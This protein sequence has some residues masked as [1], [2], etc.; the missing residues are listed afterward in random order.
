MGTMDIVGNVKVRLN[1]SAMK[2][3]RFSML[4]SAIA[5]V[6][7][8]MSCTQKSQDYQSVIPESPVVVVKA[9]VNSL[10]AKSELL[11]DNQVTGFA[12]SAINEM[13]ENTRGIL[14]EILNDPANSGLDLDKPAFVVV[15]NIENMRGFAL[16]AVSDREKVKALVNAIDDS[17]VSLDEAADYSLIKLR[18]DNLGALDDS[19]L[20]VAFAQGAFDASEYMLAED[21]AEWSDELEDFLASPEELGYYMAYRDI[22]R[23]AEGMEA[24]AFSGIDVEKFKDLKLVCNVNFNPG[25]A[26]M[27][28]SFHGSDEVKRMYKDY[29]SDAET[30][31]QRFL[32]SATMALLQGGYKNLGTCM[33]ET[34][35]NDPQMADILA[36]LNRDLKQMGAKQ[37]FT[38]SLLNSLDGG[39]VL[40]VSEID[41][42]ADLPLPQM[43]F[44]AECKDDKLFGMI[45]E[46]LQGQSGLVSKTAENVYLVAGMYYVGYADSKLFVMPAGIFNECYADNSLKG[47]ASDVAGTPLAA[48]LGEEIGLAVD[49]QAV[50][51]TLEETGM[52]R[53]RSEKKLLSVLRKFKGVNYTVNDDC[54]VECNVDFVD[55]KTNA[56]KQLKDLAVTMAIG[57]AVN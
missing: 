40:A 34:V 52:A 28:I 2:K 49:L 32:P 43:I 54:E 20:V 5:I 45:K 35:G 24:E 11:Q 38:W 4:F 1:N 29:V 53:R 50:A 19:K 17:E 9:N 16:F 26:V 48:A 14:R 41:K 44:V 21:D 25:R 6:F 33:E 18:E 55:A 10:L 7:G 3:T 13:P 8:M 56:L 51:Q 30:D 36:S 42:T 46:M 31:L 39:C 47:L 12:K 27:D 23:L 15:D 37:D 57:E 22:L